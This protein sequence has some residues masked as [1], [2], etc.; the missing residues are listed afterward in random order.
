MADALRDAPSSGFIGGILIMKKR[1]VAC[2]LMLA[3]LS[4]GVASA[5]AHH[6]FTAEYDGSKII[7]LT[8]TLT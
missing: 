1:I 6:A 7:T 5:S 4:F 8:G 2:I 3:G